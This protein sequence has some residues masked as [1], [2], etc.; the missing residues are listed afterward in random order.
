MIMEHS[1]LRDINYLVLTV[2]VGVFCRFLLL[3]KDTREDDKDPLMLE[4]N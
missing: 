3:L 1:C 2:D 4:K